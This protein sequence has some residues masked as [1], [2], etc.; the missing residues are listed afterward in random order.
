MIN[1]EKIIK[2]SAIFI[3]FYAILFSKESVFAQVEG[4]QNQEIKWLMVNSLHQ[5]F[6]NG[7]AELEYGRRGR[8][9]FE[10]VDQLDGLRWPAQYQNQDVSVGKSLWI[11]TTNFTDP[12]SG[13]TYPYKVVCSGRGYLNLGIEFTADEFKLIGKY[14]HS[15]VRVDLNPASIIDYEDVVDEYD[16]NLPCDRMIYSKFHTAIGISCTRKVY[17]FSQQYHNNYFIY[18]YVFKNTGITDMSGEQKLDK[19]LTDVVFHW[20][21]RYGFAG[22][23][24]TEGWSPTGASW[25]RNCVNDA[26]GFDDNHPVPDGFGF[27]ADARAVWAYYGPISTSAS[28]SDDIG[29]PDH[30]SGT[31]LAGTN[32]AG[33]IVLHA[34][35]SPQDNSDDPDQPTTSQFMGSDR[36]AQGVDQFNDELMRRKYADFMTAGHPAKTHAEQVG[37]KFADNWGDDAGGYASALGFGPYD[38]AIGDSVRIVFA[39]G[40]AGIM[41]DREHVREIANKWFDNEGPFDLPDGSTTDDRNEYKNTWVL[42]GE[43]SIFQTFLRAIDNYNSEFDIP[44]PPPPP[45][46]FSVN[47]G[48]NRI[49]ITWADNADTWP[50]FDG[51][52]L[53]RAIGRPDT[54]YNL[55]F[56]C[57]ADNVVHSFDDET[58]QRGFDNYYY[59]QTKD[60]GSTN[61]IEPG[62]P[63]VSSKFYTMTNTQA[64]LLRPP[65]ESLSA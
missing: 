57:D 2:L 35:A 38:L 23:S 6:S 41:K 22:E 37:S 47:S 56:E 19:T 10:S 15:N 43:D 25:G 62:V 44:Q 54:A 34:D 39:E 28:Y 45:E 53:Y 36:D 65:G 20:Q 3:I 49:S 58:A 26:F 33:V 1:R 29:L 42:S 60:D 7:G 18:E 51:Y 32:Y 13:V 46:E 50:N 64:Y 59:I 8:A 16:P 12:V 55:I 5:W 24:Y 17:A 52:R 27:P 30:E 11:G 48:G 9:G 61:D 40:V 14:P 21:H 63:L 31:I 4:P